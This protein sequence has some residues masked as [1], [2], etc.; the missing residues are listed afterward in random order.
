[1]LYWWAVWSIA[2]LVGVIW[3]I[4]LLV[5]CMGYSSIDVLYG[6]YIVCS[7]GGSYGV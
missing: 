1:M 4:A 7:I 3:G 5:G 2:L 6:V